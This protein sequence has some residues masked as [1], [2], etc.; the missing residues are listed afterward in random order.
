MFKGGGSGE[1][2]GSVKEQVIN[3]LRIAA[4]GEMAG[5]TKPMKGLD[6]GVYEITITYRKNAY[7]S[8]YAVKIEEK[9]LGCPCFLEKIQNGH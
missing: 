2:A 3:A 8:V 4:K 5:I 1:R 7:R 6:A 9:Y